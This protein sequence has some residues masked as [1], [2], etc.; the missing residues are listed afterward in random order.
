MTVDDDIQQI[1]QVLSDVMLYCYCIWHS[2][3]TPQK[4]KGS[5][6]KISEGSGRRES[7]QERLQAR[8]IGQALAAQEGP[9]T[10]PSPKVL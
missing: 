10:Y 4:D 3:R 5:T 6:G 7:M 2:G 1:V 9:V 8:E